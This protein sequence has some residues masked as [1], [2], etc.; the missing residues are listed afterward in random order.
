MCGVPREWVSILPHN[1]SRTVYS[2]CWVYSLRTSHWLQQVLREFFGCSHKSSR[3][4]ANDAWSRS[5][6]SPPC[7]G[8]RD[9]KLSDVSEPPP[10]PLSSPTFCFTSFLSDWVL[11]EWVLLEALG[12]SSLQRTLSLLSARLFLSSGHRDLLRSLMFGGH[13]VWGLLPVRDSIDYPIFGVDP[14]KLF[15]LKSPHHTRIAWHLLPW[16]I[17][18]DLSVVCL[19]GIKAPNLLLFRTSVVVVALVIFWILVKLCAV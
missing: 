12:G 1:R 3:W 16:L 5:L 15:F 14:S 6:P 4:S 17:R 11:Y 9:Q 19:A 18:F 10:P 13:R 7:E 8:D 2:H